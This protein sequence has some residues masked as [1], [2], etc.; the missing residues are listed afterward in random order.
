MKSSSRRLVVSCRGCVLQRGCDAPASAVRPLLAASFAAHTALLARETQRLYEQ[1]SY[2][3]AAYLAG[4]SL[5]RIDQNL[6]EWTDLGVKCVQVLARRRHDCV[7]R[8]AELACMLMIVTPCI[9]LYSITTLVCTQ[10]GIGAGEENKSRSVTPCRS[11]LAARARA[12]VAGWRTAA[13]LPAAVRASCQESRQERQE[14]KRVNGGI[15]APGGGAA[16]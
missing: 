4:C 15:S 12:R 3:H 13:L 7:T 10:T 14:S 5:S 6:G 8:L 1:Q 16:G 9:T 2:I 11:R